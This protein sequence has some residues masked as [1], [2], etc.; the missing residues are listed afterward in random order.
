MPDNALSTL[1]PLSK[2]MG[3][4][5]VSLDELTAEQKQVLKD[6]VAKD[7]T[8]TELTYFLN[9]ALAQGLDPF[10]KE[11]WCIKF[12]N[13]LTVQTGRDGFLKI[14]KRDPSF[15]RIQSSEVR[16]CDVFR[17]DPI[18]GEIEHRIEAKRGQILGAW[19]MI[20]RKDGTRLTKYVTFSEYNDTTSNIWRDYPSAMICKVAE[21]VLCKQFANVTGI[22][23]E[24]TMRKDGAIIDSSPAAQ[25]QQSSLKDRLIQQIEACRTPKEFSALKDV[26]AGSVGKLFGPEKDAVF[27]A[28]KA[29]K[30][31]LEA[32]DVRPDMTDKVIDHKDGDPTNNEVSNLKV[33]TASSTP[34]VTVKVETEPLYHMEDADFEE[35]LEGV[36]KQET[37]EGIDDIFAQL[38]EKALSFEQRAALDTLCETCRKQLEKPKTKKKAA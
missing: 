28:A 2:P 12:A 32:L 27:T 24:E 10:R 13:R 33:E 21:S 36:R 9:V 25:E 23:A 37:V 17:M 11:V 15:D 18:S 8:D 20:T 3:F 29:K 35:W 19:A 34:D 22:V 4:R 38:K 6:S 1:D 31:E 26:I 30:A 7:T 14:S 5:F 16:E